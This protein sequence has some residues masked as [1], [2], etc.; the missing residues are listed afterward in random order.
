MDGALG[1]SFSTEFAFHSSSP[2]HCR[3]S[4]KHKS[5]KG[6]TCYFLAAALLMDSPSARPNVA[7]SRSR[8]SSLESL[9]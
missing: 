3:S 2:S 7:A 8:T 9:S 1:R 4:W 5:K 6:K